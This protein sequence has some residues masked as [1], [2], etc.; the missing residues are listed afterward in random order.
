M[1]AMEKDSS[2]LY[3]FAR[4]VPNPAM[5]NSPTTWNNHAKD[6]DGR[7][8]NIW[9]MISLGRKLGCDMNSEAAAAMTLLTPSQPT[10]L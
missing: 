4:D 5:T 10:S 9:A 1:A 7:I 2:K 3:Q 8:S 6:L